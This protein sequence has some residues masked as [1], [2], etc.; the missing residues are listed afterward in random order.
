MEPNL[1]RAG[2]SLRD[3]LTSARFVQAPDVRVTACC[4]KPEE[5]N[6][7]DL[8]VAITAADSDGH[9]WADEAV[10][11]GAAAVLAERLLP[12]RCP[13]VIVEDS[14][15]ALGEICQSLVGRPSDSL[16][17]I[18]VTGTSG[19]TV[20]TMLIASVLEAAGQ[21]VGVTSGVGY[22]D[23]VEQV[24]APTTTPHAPLL[25]KWLARMTEA[26]CT[27][28]VLELSSRALAERRAA[29]VDFDAAVLTNLRE[30]H[31]SF[32][33]SVE[34][35]RRAKQ[36]LFSMLKPGGFAVVN[37]DDEASGELVKSL[38]S[39]VL[40]FGLQSEADVTAEIIERQRSE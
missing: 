5:V 19:K 25:G 29:G 38:D 34:N 27:S 17:T 18:G 23:S 35:Y 30:A 8:Y 26:G 10:Q 33:G 7:G 3:T 39:P 24:K 37:A 15:E 40:T 12:V 22:S 14:R 11:H 16:R 28:A 6:P 2:I 4:T 36:R 20:T 31:L 21:A 1:E 13:Q 32:H 9:E